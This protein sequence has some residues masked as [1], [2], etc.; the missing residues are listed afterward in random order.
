MAG[1]VLHLRE[2]ALRRATAASGTLAIRIRQILPPPAEASGHVHE[3]IARLGLE[4]GT[5]LTI[6]RLTFSTHDAGFVL[7][8]SAE[9]CGPRADDYLLGFSGLPRGVEQNPNAI[10]PPLATRRAADDLCIRYVS[11]R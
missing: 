2:P 4:D 9:L 6:R 11:A 10:D 7:S 3:L 5:P 1:E 8:I